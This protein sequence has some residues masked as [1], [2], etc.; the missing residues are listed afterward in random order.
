MLTEIPLGPRGD[1]DHI[2]GALRDGSF[3]VRSTVPESLLDEAYG[4]LRA[5][6]D[7]PAAAKADCRV[8]GG[9]GQ[10]GYAPPQTANAEKGTTPDCGERFCWGSTLPTGHPLRVR[11]PARYPAPYFPDHLVPGIGSALRELH[12]RMVRLQH[13][14]ARTVAGAL[15]AHPDYFS[16]MLEDG[17][18]VNRAV[19]QPPL[20]PVSTGRVPAA[21]YRH[22]DLINA[23]PRAT[24]GG[25]EVFIDHRWT[26]VDV[27]EGYAAVNVG[28]VLDRL[29]DG[30]ARAAVHRVVAGPGQREGRL[31]IAQFC[32]PAPWTTLTP[33]PIP[34]RAERPHRFPVL[35][36]EE[37]FQRTVYRMSRL[38]SRHQ[39]LEHPAPPGAAAMAGH[40]RRGLRHLG[41]RI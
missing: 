23:Q 8:P 25:L 7:L 13:D 32:H 27:P 38:D 21:E 30:L 18:V 11:F 26:P 16:E 9:N 12:G 39:P 2:R 10:S 34:G 19:W 3:L 17:P 20:D 31:S 14:V 40:A 41:D 22:F 6:F 28:T 4:F 1:R 33:L 35:T 15:G 36:A 37:L 24:A 5:F 29:T